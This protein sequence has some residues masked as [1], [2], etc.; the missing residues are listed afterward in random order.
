MDTP[1]WT[2]ADE[3]L[4]EPWKIKVRGLLS[5][6]NALEEILQWDNLMMVMGE[7]TEVK[8]VKVS[9]ALLPF[10]AYRGFVEADAC[11]NYELVIPGLPQMAMGLDQAVS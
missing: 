7:I 4:T 6:F 8:D 3:L 11:R 9:A 1:L 2:L 5:G 10:R